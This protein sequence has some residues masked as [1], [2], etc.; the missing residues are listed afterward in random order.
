MCIRDRINI[1][2]ASPNHTIFADKESDDSLSEE[3][4]FIPLLFIHFPWTKW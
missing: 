3:L 1:V 2:Q 4:K